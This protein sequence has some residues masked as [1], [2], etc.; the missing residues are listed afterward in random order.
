MKNKGDYIQVYIDNGNA[1][2]AGIRLTNDDMKKLL[3]FVQ[4]NIN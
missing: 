3:E 1:G 4:C 2:Y